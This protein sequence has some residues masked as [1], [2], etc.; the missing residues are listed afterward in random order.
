[1]RSRQAVLTLLLALAIVAAIV[2]SLIEGAPRRLPGVALGSTVLLHVERVAALFAV[3]LA[4]VSVFA[5]ANRGR[6]PT[7]LSTTGLGYPAEAE[8]AEEAMAAIETLQ[9]QLNELQ[10]Q[11][12]RLVDLTLVDPGSKG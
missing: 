4:V 9:D 12:A 1:V 11:V 2:I 7:Q 6:L 3:A 8:A 5:Q 10:Q